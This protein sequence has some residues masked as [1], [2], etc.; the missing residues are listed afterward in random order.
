[1]G[2]YRVILTQEAIYEILGVTEYIDETFGEE[3]ANLFL[4]EMEEQM[5]KLG[6]AGVIFRKTSFYYRNYS[7]YQKTFPPSIIFYIVKKLEGEVH[8]LRVLR[9]ERDWMTIIKGLK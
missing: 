7:I 5:S 9:E 3:R 1:M 2:E 8:I 6:N 4:H